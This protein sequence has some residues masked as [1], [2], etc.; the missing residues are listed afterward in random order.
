MI[1]PAESGEGRESDMTHYNGARVAAL[2]QRAPGYI[3][4]CRIC[5]SCMLVF[6]TS[7]KKFK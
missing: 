4:I 2:L 7:S 6:Q 3:S 1:V 5:D